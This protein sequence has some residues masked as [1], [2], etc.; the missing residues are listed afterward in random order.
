VDGRQKKAGMEGPTLQADLGEL[1]Q[2]LRK[3]R[4]SLLFY[5]HGGCEMASIANDQQV[6]VGRSLPADIVVPDR[7]LSREHARFTLKSDELWIEDLRSTN[8]T[9]V[10]GKR[11]EKKQRIR[12]GDDIRVGTVAVGLHQIAPTEEDLGRPDSHDYFL[13]RLQEEVLRARTLN[14]SVAMLM[15]KASGS[16][17]GH[18]LRWYPR[19]RQLLRPI[20]R[21]AVYGLDALLIYLPESGRAEAEALAKTMGAEQKRSGS[22]LLCGIACYPEH[23]TSADQLLEAV[24]DARRRATARQPIQTAESLDQRMGEMVVDEALI[25]PTLKPIYETAMR[26]ADVSMPVLICGETGTGKEVLA[27]AIHRHS[28]RGKGPIRCLNCGVIP[29]SLI[30][31]SLFGHEKG[32]FT[33]AD[34]RA[35][36]LFE[37]AEGGT[38]LLDEIGELAASAQVALLRV[39]ETKRITRVGS[40]VEIAVDVRIIAATHRDLETMCDEGTFRWDLFY[41]LNGLALKVPPLRERREDIMPLAE[42]FMRLA[43]SANRR[44][45]TLIDEN[46]RK[47]FESYDWPGNVRELRNV[48]ERAV[49]LARGE[50]VTSEDISDRIRKADQRPGGGPGDSAPDLEEG[51]A[52]DIKERL[53][54]YETKIILEALGAHGWNQ[55]KTARALGISRRTLVEKIRAY[56]IRKR[57][58]SD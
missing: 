41:R 55:T 51:E 57:Y 3:A 58:T 14:H 20:D 27:Q 49:V 31:S 8:G 11:I 21:V 4:T 30:E 2:T 54:R 7:S 15:V 43:A 10:G 28:S 46:V 50:T 40:S 13:D 53:R 1:P 37:E 52:L 25:S 33:G 19:V 38:V 17:E 48:L 23:A 26:I 5:H 9:W 22:A 32:A 42:H 6:V 45:V 16:R 44:K 56:G 39:L 29:E 35:K 18:L 36:G 24:R 34:K 12:P 47:M